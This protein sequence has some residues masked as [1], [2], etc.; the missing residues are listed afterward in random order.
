MEGWADT[1][2]SVCEDFGLSDPAVFCMELKELPEI[3]QVHV[4]P[5]KSV[6]K[7]C[8]TPNSLVY[9][10]TVRYTLIVCHQCHKSYNIFFASGNVVSRK[11]HKEDI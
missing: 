9:G 6:L 10:E 11:T 2:C 5:L 8:Q 7:R 3:E 1:I 4:L